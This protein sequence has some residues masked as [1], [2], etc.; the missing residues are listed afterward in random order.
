MRRTKKSHVPTPD[1]DVDDSGPD[2]ESSSPGSQ[3]NSS[4]TSS[5]S[6]TGASPG[7]GAALTRLHYP[8]SLERSADPSATEPIVLGVLDIVPRSTF[9]EC[10]THFV[11]NPSNVCYAGAALLAVSTIRDLI[12]GLARRYRDGTLTTQ[13]SDDEQKEVDP[14]TLADAN[15]ALINIMYV[16]SNRAARDDTTMTITSYGNLPGSNVSW[17]WLVNTH[18]ATYWANTVF[19]QG[20]AG[21]VVRNFF[22][23]YAP[24][25]V[26]SEQV[27][28]AMALVA[29]MRHINVDQIDVPPLAMQGIFIRE[30][31]GHR[32]AKRYVVLPTSHPSANTLLIKMTGLYDPILTSGHIWQTSLVAWV[33]SQNKYELIRVKRTGSN[34]NGTVYQPLEP[35]PSGARLYTWSPAS[36]KELYPDPTTRD[37]AFAGAPVTDSH[38][39]GAGSGI[40]TVTP[41]TTL[42]NN[43]ANT[44]TVQDL[45]DYRT[46]QKEYSS[47][48][49]E[50]SPSMYQT[51]IVR[52][53]TSLT[54]GP[55]AILA[56]T[57]EIENRHLLKTSAS[58]TLSARQNTGP[59]KREPYDLVATVQHEPSHYRAY[60]KS[61]NNPQVWYEYPLLPSNGRRTPRDFNHIN[62]PGAHPAV[63]VYKRRSYIPRHRAQP[64]TSLPP[65][66]TQMAVVAR[67]PDQTHSAN[68]SATYLMDIAEL[69]TSLGETGLTPVDLMNATLLG[70]SL[71]SHTLIAALQADPPTN[72]FT[73]WMGHVPVP[74]TIM[75]TEQMQLLPRLLYLPQ[76][77]L[78]QLVGR[79]PLR[80]QDRERVIE[81]LNMRVFDIGVARRMANAYIKYFNIAVYRGRPEVQGIEQDEA[82]RN[83][84]IVTGTLGGDRVAALYDEGG[85]SVVDL[86]KYV[87]KY[88]TSRKV[89]A[90][91]ITSPN[92]AKAIVGKLP[93]SRVSASQRVMAIGKSSV[94]C[95]ELANG[96]VF[97]LAAH[98]LSN[99]QIRNVNAM[100]RAA[101]QT[102]IPEVQPGTQVFINKVFGSRSWLCVPWFAMCMSHGW[103]LVMD[104]MYMLPVG[105][106]VDDALSTVMSKLARG[107]RGAS[108]SR[109]PSRGLA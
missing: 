108:A 82:D 100:L 81:W 39:N 88:F 11:Y 49:P 83:A 92:R 59:S 102:L 41:L 18:L 53:T 29:T 22:N 54:F 72:A 63:L 97:H 21:E 74:S 76:D 57:G 37:K 91:P 87:S 32:N 16:M 40:E 5:S 61:E 50:G 85:P 75:S 98:P 47:T 73:V 28:D 66:P 106:H 36:V 71:V 64:P 79:E 8:V 107:R 56:I 77:F 6:H 45:I 42:T 78:S 60:I 15:H 17:N 3:T 30:Y 109:G 65:V 95:I 33:P 31:P 34:A 51:R 13:F 43:N 70:G 4:P 20:D 80:F 44:Y 35:V 104:L 55:Y 99:T 86:Y 89:L 48:K 93:Q 84:V 7:S 90:L 96:Q 9:S 103:H 24:D 19:E 14:N 69:S 62:R 52:K 1:S 94:S 105:A 101:R 12:H 23:H 10:C 27:R 38:Q 26:D 25:S 58:L 46:G 2:E 68:P 67:V